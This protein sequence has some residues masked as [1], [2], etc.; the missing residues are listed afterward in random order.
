MA[1]ATGLQI[2]AAQ[3]FTT[4]ARTTKS[5]THKNGRSF[6]QRAFPLQDLW[7]LWQR[8]TEVVGVLAV[9]DDDVHCTGETRKL[10]GAGVRH[11]AD[12]Q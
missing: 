5:F 2:M 9:G 4:W 3:K 10:T 12:G 7:F 11:D 1:A 6:D 8:I